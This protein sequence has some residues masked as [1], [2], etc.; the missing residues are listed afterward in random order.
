MAAL[1]GGAFAVD[2]GEASGSV[3]GGNLS[4]FLKAD[5]SPYKVNE[6]LVVPEGRVLLIEAGV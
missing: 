6:T 5:H 2:T 4:G 1:H 3:I